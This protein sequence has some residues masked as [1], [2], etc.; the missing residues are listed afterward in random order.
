[1]DDISIIGQYED[2]LRAA[3]LA[4]DIAALAELL[5]DDLVFTGPDGRV[6]SKADDLL[7]HREKLLRLDRLDIRETQTHRIGE[8]I[9]TTTQAALAG[10]FGLMAFDGVF[11]YTRLW[12]QS[13]G[14]WRV[15]AGHGAKIG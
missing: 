15:V 5:D 3:M 7:A 11:A 8:M 14:R 6:L 10:H 1:M 13:G 4:N 2:A 9:L 12:K